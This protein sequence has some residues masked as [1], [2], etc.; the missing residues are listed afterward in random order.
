MTKGAY[1]GLRIAC[2]EVR[3][4]QLR[5]ILAFYLRADDS[6]AGLPCLS[7]RY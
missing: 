6:N 4:V 1:Y 2:S 7:Q 5:L 3:P